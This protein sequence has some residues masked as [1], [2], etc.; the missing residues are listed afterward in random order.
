MAGLIALVQTDIKRVI[1]YS[2]MS[3]IG[4]MFVGAGLGAYPNGDVPP[5]DARVLQGAA[6]PRRRA[7][8]STRSSGEQDIR[9]LAGIGKL[10]PFTKWVFLVGSLALVGIFPFAGFFSKD[11]IIAA[12]LDRGWF[13]DV[14]FAAGL[15]GAFLTG[16]YAFRLFFIVFTGEPIGVRARALPR[17]PRPGRAALDA[18]DGRR[19]RRALGG[20]RAGSSSRRSGI[21]SRPG[22][23][24]S[25]QPIAEA[26]NTQEW[27][28]SGARDPASASPG[29][30][31]RGRCT[32]AKR[33]R[34]AARAAAP[35][36]EVLL[37][38]ALRPDLVPHRRSR[39]ARPLRARRGSR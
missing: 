13:G 2:T 14:I 26:T 20:R 5:D 30:A 37:G 31:S 29:S 35:R 11:A 4:Y 32:R 15:V 12:A 3:Q 1:A 6:V 10:M 23:T 27:V 25:P 21:R 9:K 18:L 24:R 34:G 16:I 7:S 38:R 19:A 28:A 22:S 17:A 39:R 33:V 36:E 8:R